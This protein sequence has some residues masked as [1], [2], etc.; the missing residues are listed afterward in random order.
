MFLSLNKVSIDI[1]EKSLT[2]KS[3]SR[4][5][6]SELKP[7]RKLC[8][9]LITVLI[10]VPAWAQEGEETKAPGKIPLYIS[11]DYAQFRMQD[12]LT[13]VEYYITLARANLTF[14]PDGE[15]FKAEFMLDAKVRNRVVIIR[16]LINHA[17]IKTKEKTT[18]N[19]F[20]IN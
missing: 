12:S 4:I 13:F 15:R 3:A 17:T 7:L 5:L 1:S 9:A 10:F 11:S 2:I 14:V 6:S 19:N 20:F 16:K 8:T 18:N